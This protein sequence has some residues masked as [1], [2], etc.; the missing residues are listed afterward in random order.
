M[1]VL[2]PA[3]S[4]A[5]A[6]GLLLALSGAILPAPPGADATGAVVA[7]VNGVPI[8]EPALARALARGENS[9]GGVADPALR[10]A[11]IDRLVDEELLVQRAAEMGLV[12]SDR[13][14]RK[15]LARAAID[16]AVGAASS[17]A[18]SESELRSF[19]AANASHFSLPSRV[20]VRAISFD[21]SRDPDRALRRAREA[22]AAIAG[23]A[24]FEA[25]AARFGEPPGLPLPDA[26]LPE[27]ALRRLLG[28]TLSEA[29]LALAPG[30]VSAPL[31]VG[32]SVH[33]LELAEVEPARAQSFEAAR[34]RVAAEMARE[35]GDAALA[36]LLA[37]LR[38]Q[39]HIV[40]APEPPP[41]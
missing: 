18:P 16:A 2:R 30:A 24:S 41:A 13:S 6:A 20:R 12:T 21:A 8:R 35:R 10:A 38:A 37:T 34:S 40:R 25:A 15:A 1:R 27:A 4:L 29:A 26:L 3:Q 32:A 7:C 14:V 23:G 9:R 11:L 28:P 33:L 39:A 22:A 5:S 19:Y 17:R 36:A 31:R